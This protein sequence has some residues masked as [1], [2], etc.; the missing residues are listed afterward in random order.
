MYLKIYDS[1][2]LAIK[3]LPSNQES[4]KFKPIRTSDF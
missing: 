1:D 3:R 2:G 4:L